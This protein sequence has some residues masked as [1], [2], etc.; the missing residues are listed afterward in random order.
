MDGLMGGRHHMLTGRLFLAGALCF[1][2]W[3]GEARAEALLIPGQA[4]VRIDDGA[5]TAWQPDAN[6]LGF[7]PRASGGGTDQSAVLMRFDLS[8][9]P[10]GTVV[11]GVEL[12]LNARS[13]SDTYDIYEVLRPWVPAE[14]TSNQFATGQL[15]G[16]AGAGQVGVDI[17]AAALGSISSPG[18]LVT[19]SF[20]NAGVLAVQGW[21]GEP[22]TNLGMIV[23]D[24]AALD[25]LHWD[26]YD[27]S[28]PTQRP[29]L[30]VFHDAGTATGSPR[31]HK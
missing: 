15:W 12:I 20:T 17:G 3:S 18:G 5:E 1:A 29:Q 27:D 31:Q 9:L 14:A 23:R 24:S 30:I 22:I 21:I 4:D 25:P 6:Y 19:V 13:S 16:M 8:L 2:G 7:A 11:T 28:T 10:L 26:G